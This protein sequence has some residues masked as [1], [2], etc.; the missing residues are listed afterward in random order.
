[1][2]LTKYAVLLISILMA[3]NSLAYSL[4]C[5]GTNSS[6]TYTYDRSD[7]GAP[8]MPFEYLKLNGTELINATVPNGPVY[9]VATLTLGN[10]VVGR[11]T[12]KGFYRTSEIAAVATVKMIKGSALETKRNVQ[13]K[14]TIYMGPP[15]P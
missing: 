14:E 2:K 1:M 11:V 3:Q 9:K 7:G 15:R 10:K 4:R 12:S 6:L 8:R 5:E 13:C